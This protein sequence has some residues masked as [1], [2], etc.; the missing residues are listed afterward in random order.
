VFAPA[1]LVFARRSSDRQRI[2]VRTP[3]FGAAS[4]PTPVAWTTQPSGSSQRQGL[5]ISRESSDSKRLPRES[6]PG[7]LSTRQRTAPSGTSAVAHLPGVPQ[8]LRSPSGCSD[9]KPNREAS[10]ASTPV[11]NVFWNLVLERWRPGGSRPFAG[12]TRGRA[13]PQCTSDRIRS[14]LRPAPAES[15]R[16]PHLG[17]VRATQSQ[18]ASSSY[19]DVNAIEWLSISFGCRQILTL[20]RRRSGGSR[21]PQD[22]Q[23]A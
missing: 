4:H 15:D 6:Q 5:R 23:W 17:R 19:V 11:E 1:K 21:P 10:T 2:S 9:V 14:I 20:A 16:S 13:K 12:K 22:E 8:W 18:I 3:L 7:S